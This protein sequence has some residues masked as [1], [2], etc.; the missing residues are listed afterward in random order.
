MPVVFRDGPY[1]FFFWSNERN[2]PPHIHVESGDGYAKF[3][4]G[5]DVRLAE[6]HGYDAHE[7]RILQDKVAQNAGLIEER[8]YEH[9]GRSGA[10][11]GE[12]ENE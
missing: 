2:E 4:V 11:R 8:W 5:P 10:P 12:A 1:R 6:S 3:W 9:F 7:V